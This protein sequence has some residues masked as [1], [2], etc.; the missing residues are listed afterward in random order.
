MNG[1]KLP[2]QCPRC[3][4]EFAPTTARGRPRGTES[5]TNAEV[6]HAV[7]AL[8]RQGIVVTRQNVAT[9]LGLSPS[10]LRDMHRRRGLSWV[11][12]LDL[13]N[14]DITVLSPSPGTRP[15]AA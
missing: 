12:Y 13:L 8:R 9:Q 5:S 10:G 4:F 15:S 11:A 1:A 3:G 7:A 6:R 14:A 2:S